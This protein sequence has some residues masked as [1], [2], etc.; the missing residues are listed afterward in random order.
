VSVVGTRAYV[1]DAGSG[2]RVIDSV[3]VPEPGSLLLQLAA[4]TT[5]LRLRARRR[6]VA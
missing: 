2:L 5:L 6:R 3:A 4:A 1:A